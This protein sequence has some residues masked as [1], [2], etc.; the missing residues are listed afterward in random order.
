MAN[1][2]HSLNVQDRFKRSYSKHH[3]QFT[4]V[5]TLLPKHC[6]DLPSDNY[7]DLPGCPQGAPAHAL[8]TSSCLI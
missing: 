3:E 4:T 8:I 5:I 2:G 7:P 1:M 6:V